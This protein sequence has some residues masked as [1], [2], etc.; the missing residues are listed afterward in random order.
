MTKRLCKLAV[1]DCFHRM[2][3]MLILIYLSRAPKTKDELV[4]AIALD[5]RIRSQNQLSYRFNTIKRRRWLQLVNRPSRNNPGVYT[6][7]PKGER[8][9]NQFQ[10]ELIQL[11]EYMDGDRD[12]FDA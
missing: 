9:L 6:L 7:S 1:F 12:T 3:E 2:T 11:C 5:S 4:N 8:A 10:R